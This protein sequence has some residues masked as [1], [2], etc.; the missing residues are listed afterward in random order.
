MA[1]AEA[2][3]AE[4]A[5]EAIFGAD[6]TEAAVTGEAEPEPAAEFLPEPEPEPAAEFLP[7]PEPGPAAESLPDSEPE[8][9]LAQV[10]E[11]LLELLP[12]EPVTETES[13]EQPV[14][15]LS[16]SDLIDRFISI[17]PT[18]ERM[19]PGEYQPVRDLSEN[20]TEEEATFITETLAK[21]YVNQGYYTKAI[22]IY[23]KLSL[24]YP[25]KSAYFAGRIEKIEELIK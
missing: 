22:N 12:D 8:T 18:I 1:A 9:A 7:E 19:K 20:G 17:S 4:E 2:V 5:D 11:E 10:H 21:I 6:E 3:I 16:P 13:V 15:E 24:Q 23:Q 14:K 25:E